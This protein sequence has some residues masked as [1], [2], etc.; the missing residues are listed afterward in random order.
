[1]GDFKVT[2]YD[3]KSTG[4]LGGVERLKKT[5]N[6]PVIN[7]LR[8]EDAYTLHK[9]I[10]RKFKRRRVVV[11]GVDAQWQADLVDVK[12][13]KKWNR[14]F[15]YLLT[16]IDVFSK[17]AW[18]IPLKN[19]TGKTL[20]KAFTAILKHKRKPQSLQTDKG[21]EF[22][23]RV[24]QKWLQTNKI[25]FFTTHNEETKASIVERFNRTLKTRMWR[26]FTA[27]DTKKYID[28]VDDL[29]DSYNHSYHRTIKR[30]PVSVNF[31]NQEE[32]WHTMYENT[33]NRKPKLLEGTLVRI[34]K[35]KQKFE[36]GYL[37]NWTEEIFIIHEAIGGDPPYYTLKDLAYEK[38]EGTFYEQELQQVDKRN[39]VFR[40]E[41][42][43]ATRKKGKRKE[44]LIKWLGYPEK[45]NSWVGSESIVH[46][47]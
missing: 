17:F 27:K 29:T 44:F 5:V 41:D 35:A 37:P 30:S 19:K 46:Y 10:K 43:L 20:V 15:Q 9:P 23:N 8:G 24:F 45:F 3:P 1:M 16:C 11:S 31:T 39:D 42:V 12:N 28:V 22:T 40:I 25:H 34:S 13:L 26:Y 14:Q 47:V 36:K 6:K 4:S 38:L 33:S 2:Y 21:S 32:V 7:W 18:V